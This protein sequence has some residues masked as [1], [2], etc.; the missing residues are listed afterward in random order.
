MGVPCPDGSGRALLGRVQLPSRPG[1]DNMRP[2]GFQRLSAH[3]QLDLLRQLG[4]GGENG[5]RSAR[6]CLFDGAHR[7]HRLGAGG[8]LEPV[9]RHV[10]EQGDTTMT[11]MPTEAPLKGKV[12]TTAQGTRE[13]V[14]ANGVTWSDCASPH[15]PDCS[16]SPQTRILW[17][18]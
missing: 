11:L 9:A 13:I 2:R 18:S 16:M 1:A 6:R 15:A 10:D 12:S 17:H 3:K 8:V 4:V 7:R 5:H 14:W